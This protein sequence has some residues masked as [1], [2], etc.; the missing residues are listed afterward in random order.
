MPSDNSPSSSTTFNICFDGS[1][2]CKPLSIAHCSICSVSLS[3]LIFSLL[4]IEKVNC[5]VLTHISSVVPNDIFFTVMTH[6]FIHV[7]AL[8]FSDL[9]LKPAVSALTVH[10]SILLQPRSKRCLYVVGCMPLIFAISL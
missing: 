8:L 2:L 3:M 4:F 9:S 10:A 5:A 7:T 6:L 1:A